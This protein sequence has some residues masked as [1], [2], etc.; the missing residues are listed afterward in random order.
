M[1]L[2]TDLSRRQALG[3]G[4]L[5]AFG[6]SVT[7]SALLRGDAPPA[8]P[9]QSSA[10]PVPSPRP[11]HSVTRKPRPT[12]TPIPARRTPAFKIHDIRPD[13]PARSIALTI[14][15]GPSRE[16]TPKVLALLDRHDVK[17]TFCVIGMEVRRF[18]E[19]L[20]EIVAA[21]H[22]VANHTM[23]HPVSFSRLSARGVEKEIRDAHR[24]IQDVGGTT[25]TLFRAPGGNWS[26]TV[27]R[28]AARYGMLPIDWD[29]DPRDWSRPG[30]ER[31][32]RS[33]L[34]GKGGDILLCHDGGGDRSQTLSSLR[35]VVPRLK[36]RG[37]EFITL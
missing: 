7:S 23:H 20:R 28:T 30:A 17:A 32:T 26:P 21:G 36:D 2:P 22:Q 6:V 5:G 16:W 33:L 12:P 34:R 8:D 10:L 11:A 4:A 18:P 37:L 15:D 14:D 13:A 29:I 9:R 19:L 3:L 35:K 24:R 1:D 27:M 31:I 25:P